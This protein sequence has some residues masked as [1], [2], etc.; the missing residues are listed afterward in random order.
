MKTNFEFGEVGK[1]F[2]SGEFIQ[3]TKSLWWDQNV[4]TQ[5]YVTDRW[6]SSIDPRIVSRGSE[7][8]TVFIIIS[9]KPSIDHSLTD[10][11]YYYYSSIIF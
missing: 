3:I 4:K 8:I 6:L 11:Y 10:H 1:K 5:V 9:V 7:L 2:K